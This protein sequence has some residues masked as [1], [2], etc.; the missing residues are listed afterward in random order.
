MSGGRAPWTCL[1]QW[2]ARERASPTPKRRKAS[3]SPPCSI[4]Q[5]SPAGRRQL[6]CRNS[7][8]A[9]RLWRT[10]GWTLAGVLVLMLLG[11]AAASV[12]SKRLTRP[13][14]A[15]IPMAFA[16]GRG[17]PIEIPPLHVKEAD[18]LAHALAEGARL[19]ERRTIERD[20]AEAQQQQ[21]LAAKLASEE[22][23]RTRSAW[24]AYL[25]HE[26]RTPLSVMLGCSDLIGACAR[27][28]SANFK[29]SGILRANRQDGRSPGRGGE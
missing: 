3:A 24:F 7:E 18:D 28:G 6:L 5:R 23:A 15:L 27:S 16:H 4:T 25:S 29:D 8:L 1:P 14:E 17:E 10:L 20:R 2:R 26:L 13:F 12:I 19:L 21:S 9:I 11:L 22:V